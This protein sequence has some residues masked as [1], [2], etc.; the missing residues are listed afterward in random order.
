MVVRGH[1]WPK[2]W[3][4]PERVVPHLL[5]RREVAWVLWPGSH[6]CSPGTG[7]GALSGSRFFCYF[8]LRFDLFSAAVFFSET[9]SMVFS[10]CI[11]VVL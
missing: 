3:G 6:M 2:K 9:F 4:F 1:A 10:N 11:I 5:K 8:V 7:R